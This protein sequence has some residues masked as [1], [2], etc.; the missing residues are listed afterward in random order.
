MRYLTTDAE[1]FGYCVQAR[2]RA[3]GAKLGV[4][5]MRAMVDMSTFGF[6]DEH[7]AEF[8]ESIQKLGDF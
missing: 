8:N 7:S 3:A 2:T 5:N 4:G 1:A 6:R